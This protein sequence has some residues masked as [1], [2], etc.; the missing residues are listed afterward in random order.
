MLRYL[1]EEELPEKLSVRL[2]S[3]AAVRAGFASQP[4]LFRVGVIRLM[5]RLQYKGQFFVPFIPTKHFVLVFP[6]AADACERGKL[7]EGAPETI[8]NFLCEM[9]GTGGEEEYTI[10]DAGLCVHSGA[11]LLILRC[12]SV[13]GALAAIE[14]CGEVSRQTPQMRLSPTYIQCYPCE[15]PPSDTSLSW[16]RKDYYFIPTCVLCADRLE[17]SLTG[18]PPDAVTCCCALSGQRCTCL[19][20]SRCVVCQILHHSQT[21]TIA[22]KQVKCQDCK[23][24]GDPWICLICGYV[25]CSRYQA[26]H[27]KE[28]C[29]AKQHF[30]SINLLTQQIWDYYSD[31]FVHQV[32]MVFDFA[33]GSTTRVRYPSREDPVFSDEND[34]NNGKDPFWQKKSVSAKYDAKLR[35][36]HT[37]YATVI[38]NELDAMRQVYENE[39][40]NSICNNQSGSLHIRRVGSNATNL[41]SPSSPW[42][43]EAE[44][45]FQLNSSPQQQRTIRQLHDSDPFAPMKT[46]NLIMSK[47]LDAQETA[48]K[49]DLNLQGLSYEIC[50]H[51]KESSQ[52]EERVYNA[53]EELRSIVRKN[54]ASVMEIDASIEE[55]KT[56]LKEI[57]LNV[58]TERRLR[59]QLGASD[60]TDKMFIMGKGKKN[61]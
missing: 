59:S 46:L 23:Q 4:I 57:R 27:A 15:P 56:T 39:I 9:L 29:I 14:A 11:A 34:N 17:A 54:V 41:A 33:S 49:S 55:M 43:S 44:P 13:E 19:A 51:T 36:S 25:G 1:V 48:L 32:V 42:T 3:P 16:Y 58:E 22:Q 8:S 6:A 5:R 35:A 24:S 26:M 28:H 2:D 37:Q 60:T 47:V 52:L 20:A 12:G 53:E 38:K 10:Q 61:L 30:F 18:F 50:L 7:A 45:H 21:S 40:S 31:A